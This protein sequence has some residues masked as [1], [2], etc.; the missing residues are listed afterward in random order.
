[1]ATTLRYSDEIIDPQTFE[2]L[3]NL[4]KP[5]EQEMKLAND[6][7]N[8]LSGELDLSAYK[9]EY[10]ERI[11]GLVRSKMGDKIVIIENKKEKPAAKSLMDALR[12]TAE[13]LK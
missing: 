4:P 9:D 12:I 11:E 6:I 5:G 3:K 13:S 1:M 8:G 10:E 7:V 2:Q